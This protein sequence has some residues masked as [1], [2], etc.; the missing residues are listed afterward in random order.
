MHIVCGATG[1]AGAPRP[2]NESLRKADA[3]TSVE[4]QAAAGL[5]VTAVF[6]GED[7]RAPSLTSSFT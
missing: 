6:A 4:P 7:A 3:Q 5:P 2:L 1:S